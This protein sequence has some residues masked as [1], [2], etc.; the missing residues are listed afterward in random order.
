MIGANTGGL[1][2]LINPVAMPRGDTLPTP[3]QAF[4]REAIVNHRQH[5]SPRHC[6]A[7]PN[8]LARLTPHQ[9]K[10][11]MGWDFVILPSSG[12]HND[13]EIFG[14]PQQLC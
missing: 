3:G 14:I 8:N 4:L 5:L 1:E 9:H 10:V 2:D 7:F 6:R 12:R 13:V 11:R